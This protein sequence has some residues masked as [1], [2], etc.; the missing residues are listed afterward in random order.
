[1]ILSSRCH[2]WAVVFIK[3]SGFT[4][5]EA[6]RWCFLCPAD[7]STG[8]TRSSV[9]FRYD[10]WQ[11]WTLDCALRIR[12]SS[13]L[14][15]ASSSSSGW[16]SS[17]ET[18][19]SF[20]MMMPQTNFNFVFLYL[21]LLIIILCCSV[22]ERVWS[23][24]WICLGYTKT[25]K[26]IKSSFHPHPVSKPPI[27]TFHFQNFSFRK[28]WNKKIISFY[29]FF[30]FFIISCN[31]RWYYA[32]ALCPHSGSSSWS[33]Y[34]RVERRK[35]IVGCSS[36]EGWIHLHPERMEEKIRL[37]KNGKNEM[38]KISPKRWKTLELL[39]WWLFNFFLLFL[40]KLRRF[41]DELIYQEEQYAV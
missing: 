22:V 4:W 10:I 6:K 7:P 11:H 23:L 5:T 19:L 3:L 41:Y 29:D 18:F 2:R 28:E 39:S 14:F 27:S 9:K 16:K 24:G 31:N 40:G 34:I 15:A 36:G 8:L 30:A 37:E 26:S 21:F 25:M 38:N 32:A 1:M 20:T 13:K 17:S 12:F 33:S 35:A